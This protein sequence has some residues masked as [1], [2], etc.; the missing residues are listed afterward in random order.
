MC[1]RQVSLGATHSGSVP[2][3]MGPRRRRSSDSGCRPK[4]RGLNLMRLCGPG[5]NGWL[6]PPRD[7]QALAAAMRPDLCARYSA[8]DLEWLSASS[9]STRSLSKHSPCTI[10][11]FQS[12][13]NEAHCSSLEPAARVREEDR[14]VCSPGARVRRQQLTLRSRGRQPRASRC[15]AFQVRD[16]DCRALKCAHEVEDLTSVSIQAGGRPPMR[17][18]QTG[19]TST[20]AGFW[21]R[22]D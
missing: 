21:R 20:R 4:H 11:P 16:E 17:E 18:P 10:K 22:L 6:V 9:R 14:T 7:L 3:S 12:E 2:D 8:V 1:G 19:R 15:P 13:S 5:E